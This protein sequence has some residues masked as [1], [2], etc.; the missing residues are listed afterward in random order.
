MHSLETGLTKFMTK[1]KIYCVTSMFDIGCT[2]LDWSILY[3]SG[4]NY[5]YHVNQRCKLQLPDN[6][7]TAV[8]AHEYQK[9][10]PHNVDVVAKAIN[11]LLKQDS[12]SITSL[13][14]GPP[15]LYDICN[16]LN[17]KA[18]DAS[19]DSKLLKKILDLQYQGYQET[20]DLFFDQNLPVIYVALDPACVM[21][22]ITPR[23]QDRFAWKN[24]KLTNPSELQYESY[25]LFFGHPDS[26]AHN[27]WDQREIIALNIRPFDLSH[28]NNVNGFKNKHMWIDSRSLWTSGQKL[29]PQVLD[30]LELSL[31]RNRFEQ[32]KLVYAQW[33]ENLN[34]NL[35]F[36]ESL[37]H[38]VNA[39][40]NN[41]YY[42]LPDLSLYQ[43]AVI[44][45]CLIYQHNLNIKNWQLSKFPNN[46]Q[47]LHKLLEPNIHPLS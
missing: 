34:D 38:I 41:W 22:L 35:I 25:E 44:Q 3:L 11:E 24:Q 15:R 32:W 5:Y 37:D 29:L 47:Q 12:C 16:Q 14:P 33:Q 42:Q 2:F 43:E 31:D 36:M 40:V 18:D 39:I 4:Q 45:H 6:P 26:S 9:N 27:I 20:I 7:L 21:F 46:T 19:S 30:Y 28:T 13:Y 17:V 10:H 1:S 8:N 23:G